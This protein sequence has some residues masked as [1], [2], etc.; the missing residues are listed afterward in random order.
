MDRCLNSG[1]G[2]GGQGVAAGG[3]ALGGWAFAGLLGACAAASQGVSFVL[4]KGAGGG[5]FVAWLGALGQGGRSLGAAHVEAGGAA[6][7]RRGVGRARRARAQRR[8]RAGGRQGA[9]G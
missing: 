8:A 2:G 3:R 6:W 1:G 7:S 4:T 9:L 5:A